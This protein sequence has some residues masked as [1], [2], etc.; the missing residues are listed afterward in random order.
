MSDG[1]GNRFDAVHRANPHI[2]ALFEAMALRL[3]Q[4]GWKRYSSDAILHAVRWETM[5]HLAD[6]TLFKINNDWSAFYARK[7]IQA[8]PVHGGFFELRVS[9]ADQVI[10][11]A[12]PRQ[13]DLWGP[14][15]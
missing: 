9:Q 15:P 13:P 5:H 7:F 3:I 12:D 1:L 4:R 2:Y 14:S 6:G 11:R 8:H 10:P